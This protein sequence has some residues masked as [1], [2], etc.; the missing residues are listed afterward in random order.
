MK[1]YLVILILVLTV[2]TAG[3]CQS[4]EPVKNNETALGQPAKTQEAGKETAKKT[5]VKPFTI[6]K[7][8]WLTPGTKWVT[9][10]TVGESSF[11]R[12]SE[13]MGTM[14]VDGIEYHIVEASQNG[15]HVESNYYNVSDS[16][17]LNYI[18][19][20]GSGGRKIMYQPPQPV[21]QFPLE[22]GKTWKW[23]GKF[24]KLL[25]GT[26]AYKV[27]GA[28]EVEVPAGKFN[29]LKIEVNVEIQDSTGNVKTSKAVQWYAKDVGNVKIQASMNIN[30][31]EKA[32][33]SELKSFTSA[34]PEDKE[35]KESNNK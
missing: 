31:K 4:R 9:R 8:P 10:I 27:V 18:K 11:D 16:G 15:T 7:A 20:L 6:T 2:L 13:V 1:K 28:E 14:T 12:N 29:A 17:I 26:Q 33:I 35:D 34:E 3:S 30:G 5:E 32:I 22:V 23:S 21:L 19:I 24:S 25:K